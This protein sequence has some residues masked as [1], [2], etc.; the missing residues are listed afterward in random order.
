MSAFGSK[1]DSDLRVS[2]LLLTQSGHGAAARLRV[3]RSRIGYSALMPADLN[4][5]PHFSLS[6]PINLPNVRQS[7]ASS[8]GVEASAVNLR[9]A[10]EIERDIAAFVT[11]SGGGLIVA[12]SAGAFAPANVYCWGK[13]GHCP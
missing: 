12:A 13:S 7:A 1:A 11:T 2:C 9:N 5:L 8:F 6:A 3:F 10:S 4:T